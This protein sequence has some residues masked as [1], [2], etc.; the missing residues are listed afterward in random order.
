MAGLSRR[1][2]RSP[3]VLLMATVASLAVTFAAGFRTRLSLVE[4]SAW[5]THTSDVKLAVEDCLV[6]LGRND[7]DGLRAAE[8]KVERLTLD[9]PRQQQAIARAALLTERGEPATLADL[10]GAMQREEDRLMLERVQ[11]LASART[12][13]WVV[14]TTGA[15]LT[16]VFGFA[17]IALLRAQRRELARQRAILAAIIESVDEGIIALG[18]SRE[19]LALNGAARSFWGASFPKDRWPEDWSPTLRAT[20]EDG[21]DMPPERGPLA[22]ALRGET[23]EN[24]IYQVTTAGESTEAPGRWV[25]AS[26]RPIRDDLGRLVAAVTTMRDVTEQRASAQR[27]RDQS[28]TDELTGLLNRRGFM[29]MASVRLELARRNKAPVALLYADV[30]GLKPINDGMGHE[31]GD[32]AIHD[33]GQVLRSVFRDGDIVARIGGDEFVALLPNFAPNAR[34]PLLDRLSKAIRAHVEREQRP[35]RLSI[36]ADVTSVDWEH[37]PSLEEL[38]ADADRRMYQRKRERAAASSPYLR[39]INPQDER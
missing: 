27:L 9:N 17:A 29:T 25:S 15:V 34:E 6:A 28:M 12:T 39:A 24:E 31:Q 16:V 35:Y 23:C 30:N 21:S 7:V 13:G 2:P 37:P 26:A 8:T 19:I 36:S 33:A 20:Y 5:V 1:L 14:L 18:P 3:W 11:R 4:A 38:L 32:R 10:F 22:R